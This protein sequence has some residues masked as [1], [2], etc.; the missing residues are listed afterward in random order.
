M[1]R[2]TDLVGTDS[3]DM[4]AEQMP[5]PTDGAGASALAKSASLREQRRRQIE[6]QGRPTR[7]WHALAGPTTQEKRL[8]ADER[9]WATG[10]QG[11]QMLA[12]A[13]AR[14]CPSVPMLHDRR[15]PRSRANIDHLAFAPTGIHVI[16][17]KRYRGKIEVHTPLFG[18]PRLKIAGRDRTKLIDGLEKQVAAVRAILADIAE[19]VPVSGSLCFLAPEGL[20]ADSGLPVLRTLK[21]RGYPLYHPKRLAKHLLRDGPVSLERAVELHAELA[22]RLRPAGA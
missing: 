15:M 18:A 12:E 10:A 17:A 21:I 14:R 20:L 2:P 7:V 1:S 4:H 5:G 3:D 11:E 22:L 9:H 16:D 6:A 13:L 8:I 19:D